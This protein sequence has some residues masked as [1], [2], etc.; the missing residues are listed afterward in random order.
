[1]EWESNC[2]D[3]QPISGLDLIKPGSLVKEIRQKSEKTLT[4]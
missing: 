4:L 1:M 2:K 3:C